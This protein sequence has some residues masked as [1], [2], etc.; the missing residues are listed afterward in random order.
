[1]DSRYK[2]A[3]GSAVPGEASHW[4]PIPKRLLND[5]SL[6]FSHSKSMNLRWCGMISNFWDHILI[7]CFRDRQ[8]DTRHLENEKIQINLLITKSN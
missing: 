7:V 8:T 5:I 3:R 4:H 2:I 1:M 6:L